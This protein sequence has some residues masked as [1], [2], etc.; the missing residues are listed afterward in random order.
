MKSVT[1]YLLLCSTLFSCEKKMTEQEVVSIGLFKSKKIAPY[2][3]FAGFDTRQIAL[4][5]NEQNITGLALVQYRRDERDSVKHK[6]WQHPSWKKMGHMGSITSDENGTAYTAPIPVINTLNRNLSNIN[7]IYYVDNNT[8]EMKTLINLPKPD[9]VANVVPFGVLGLYYDDHGHKL[10]ASSVAGSTR[11]QE[12]GVIYVIDPQKKII[13]D[14]FENIDAFGLLVAGYTGKK[15]LYFGRARKPDIYSIELN[16]QGLL[17]GS[18][19]LEFSLAQLG[20][21]GNDKARRIRIDNYG[22]LFVFGV[23]FNFNLAAQ[24]E[25][26]ETTYRFA[27]N[28]ETKIWKFINVRE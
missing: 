9:S 14:Q 6:I 8:G 2:T 15:R 26:L 25:K 16:R 21:R 5:T 11:E 28:P 12:K 24:T 13:V 3:K 10:Y 7:T 18:E 22:N 17:K 23:D 27:F 1:I 19:K 20:P 4:S